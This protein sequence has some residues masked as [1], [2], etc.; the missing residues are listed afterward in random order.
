MGVNIPI[1]HH[2]HSDVESGVGSGDGQQEKLFVSDRLCDLRGT[3]LAEHRVGQVFYDRSARFQSALFRGAVNA[4]CAAGYDA[5][6]FRR[7]FRNGKARKGN[8]LIRHGAGPDVADQRKVRKRQ[9]PG[10]IEERR[11]LAAEFLF[12]RRGI[13][14]IGARN[15]EDP[16]VFK[17][18]QFKDQAGVARDQTKNS[19]CKSGR[20]TDAVDQIL[21]RKP[22]QILRLKTQID[23][24]PRQ[25]RP[26]GGFERDNVLAHA[27][28]AA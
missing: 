26:F 1:P 7:R 24:L 22:E 4:L 14:V 13:V 12:Q 5:V 3:K 18:L 9:V 20:Q 17:L 10:V 28:M 27:E 15:D 11:A 25:F 21:T 6:S 2:R 8:V 16:R 19:L 23:E